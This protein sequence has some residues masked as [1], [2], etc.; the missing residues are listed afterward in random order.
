MRRF[1]ALLLSVV[2]LC[3]SAAAAGESM[4]MAGYDDQSS[5]RDWT[6]NLFFERMQTRT[7]VSFTLQQYDSLEAWTK[8]KQQMLSGGEMPDVMFKAELTVSE[9]RALYQAGKLIDLKPY[10]AEHMPNLSALLAA[11]PEWERAITLEDGAI[12]ALP[13]INEL[14][15][16]NAMWIN[17]TWLDTLGLP[18]PT[19]ADELLEALRAFRDRDPNGNSKRDEK[20]VSFMGM[21]DLRFLGHA[22]GLVANDY[23]VYQDEAG[24]V[25]SILTRDENRAFLEWLH[26]LW[27]EDLLDHN[28]FT[29]ADSLRKVTD[30]DATMTYGLFLAP[31]PR[32]L[33]PSKALDQYELLMPLTFEGKQSYRDTLG[34]VV[35]GAFAVTSA[36]EDV[37][38]VLKW[39][40]YLY[41][42]EGCMLSQ[43]GEEDV[44]FA[45]NSDGSWYWISAAEEVTS[46]VMPHVTIADGGTMPGYVSM[47]FQMSFD[48][49]A[50]MKVVRQ[51]AQ[52][53]EVSVE[54]VPL[55]S[56]DDAARARLN[57]VHTA[58]AS[59]AE[60]AMIRFVTGEVPLNDDTWHTFCQTVTSLGLGE[61]IS[62]WQD[63][64]Q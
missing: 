33:L 45:R 51:L 60:V 55:V 22:F 4:V 46:Y 52:L 9:T 49:A 64:I 15:N 63:A 19:T 16:N 30:S 27:Q 42:E 34:D 5:G 18:V 41:G 21:W 23:Y 48:E 2:L 61:V 26:L 10:I 17:R 38:A 37:P 62:I 28:G 57:E 29:T 13:M 54:P 40:D 31:T 6:T 25:Q 7:G 1:I 14:Q 35:R 3:L 44:D 20:P 24:Q 39:V 47:D 36:C 53:K 56:L 50:T 58:V 43:A 32:T 12:V 11:H 8:A 59:Y